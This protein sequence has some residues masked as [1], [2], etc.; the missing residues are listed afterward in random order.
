MM[1]IE[2]PDVVGYSSDI[3][4]LVTSG[5][6]S[7]STTNG[8]SGQIHDG[9][10]SNSLKALSDQKV[11]LVGPMFRAWAPEQWARMVNF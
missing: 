2:G 4:V 3:W 7:S 8:P 5:N 1:V 6:I 11:G 10:K 9:Q